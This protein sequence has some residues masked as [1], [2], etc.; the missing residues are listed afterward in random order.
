MQELRARDIEVRAH[1]AAHASAGGSH[2][3]GGASF[4]FQTGPDGKQY[5][6]GGEVSIDASPVSGD[7][8]A[9][10]SKARTVRAAALAPASPSGADRAVAARASQTEAKAMTELAQQ[11]AEQAVE[12]GGSPEEADSGTSTSDE[13]DDTTATEAGSPWDRYVQGQAAAVR[14]GHTLSLTARGGLFCN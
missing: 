11:Q 7:P 8:Q 6:I 14:S 2:V 1:E 10:A 3:R 12:A 5:A 4:S 9:T 13:P